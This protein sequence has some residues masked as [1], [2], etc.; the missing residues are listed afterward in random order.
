MQGSRAVFT[1]TSPQARHILFCGIGLRKCR[2]LQSSSAEKPTNVYRSPT[3][4]TAPLPALGLSRL[5]Q[6]RHIGRRRGTSCWR[7][8][9]MNNCYKTVQA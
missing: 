4:L 2:G 1:H 5:W 6:R 7:G 8:T 3:V 9:F